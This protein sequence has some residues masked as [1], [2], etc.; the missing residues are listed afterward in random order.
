MNFV[1]DHPFTFYLAVHKCHNPVAVSVGMATFDFTWERQYVGDQTA[2]I[3]DIPEII[4]K[5]VGQP[6]LRLQVARTV[7]GVVM[8]LGVWIKKNGQWIKR[9]PLVTGLSIP[10]DTD[11]CPTGGNCYIVIQC[12]VSREQE[13]FVLQLFVLVGYMCMLPST[14]TTSW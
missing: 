6:Y 3:G 4:G 12:C 8:S 2:T 1:D 7:S 10:L 5:V 11:D 9:V 14:Y 13:R